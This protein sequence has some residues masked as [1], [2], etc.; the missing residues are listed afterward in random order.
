MSSGSWSWYQ[1]IITGH[2]VWCRNGL[3]FR[4]DGSLHIWHSVTEW[5]EFCWRREEAAARGNLLP[6]YPWDLKCQSTAVKHAQEGGRLCF[7][8]FRATAL[9]SQWSWRAVGN[10]EASTRATAQP[11]YMLKCSVSL[12]DASVFNNSSFNI[13]VLVEYV[14]VFPLFP[15][16]CRSWSMALGPL[17]AVSSWCVLTLLC[18]FSN[19]PGDLQPP[20]CFR[21]VGK[22]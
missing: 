16:S 20:P 8:Y 3:P 6:F 10:V 2:R 5:R 11:V 19:L 21:G 12:Y 18:D 4:E 7:Y 14:K 22:D 9:L 15:F 1:S 13:I 17:E